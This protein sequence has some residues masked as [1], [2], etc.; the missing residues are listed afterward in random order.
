MLGMRKLDDQRFDTIVQQ[1]VSRLPWLCPEWTDHNAHDPGITILELMAWYKEMLQYQMDQL[2]PSLERRLLALAGAEPLAAKAAVCALED[3]I[4]QPRPRLS[5][6]ENQQGI[7][8]ELAEPIGIRH[9]TLKRVMVGQPGQHTNADGLL[10][11][12][13]ELC[14]FAFGGQV[15]SELRLGFSGTPKEDIRLWFEVV[16]PA[17]VPRSPFAPGQ[18]PPRDIAWAWQ[19]TGQVQPLADETHALS[20]S[21][22]ITLPAGGVPDED[23]LYWLCLRLARAGCEEQPRL[24]G[25][26][27]CRYQAVQQQTRAKSYRFQVDAGMAEIVLDDALAAEAELAVFLRTAQGWA[28]CSQYEAAFLP[29]KGRVIQV[30]AGQAAQDG[31]PNCMVVCLDPVHLQGLLFD[32]IGRPHEGLYLA[33]QGQQVLHLTLLCDTLGRDGTVRPALWHR[34]DDL[35]ACGP[36]DHVFTYDAA[37]ETIHFGNGQYGAVPVPGKGSVLVSELVLS[38]C[39]A[40]NVPAGAGLHFA[41]DGEA[42]RNT[43]A[44]GGQDAESNL[45]ARGRLLRMIQQTG[46][47]L[48]AADYEAQAC[49]TPGLRVAAAKALPGYDPAA[50]AGARRPARVAVV[51]LPDSGQPCPMPD[52]RVLAAVQRQLYPCRTVCIQVQAVPPR[53]VEFTVTLHLRASARLD[54]AQVAQR[55]EAAGLSRTGIGASVCRGDIAACVQ[56]LSGVLEIRQLELHGS[57]NGIYLAASGDLQIPPDCI[58]VLERLDF[59]CDRV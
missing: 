22:Y 23:G 26:S 52:S 2:T 19:G 55:L 7:C 20:S 17:G 10:S 56:H 45:S 38:A 51:V 21:G 35:Y 16:P 29:Q 14:P 58:A 48:S 18:P 24:S 43:A 31:Q 36:R 37:R 30:D 4:G 9:M 13:L 57:G 42:I 12:N 33:T 27:D 34:V 28:Q 3:T 1:A 47:C 39:G 25:I 6:L 54:G 46:K 44:A 5:R 8:F 59:T 11:G 49:R 32:T 53:Y 40:G 41:A 15:G 50:P